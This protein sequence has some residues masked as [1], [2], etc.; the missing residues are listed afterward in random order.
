MQTS[1]AQATADFA[2]TRD[3]MASLLA[4]VATLEGD[5]GAAGAPWTPGRSLS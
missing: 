1:L 4:E 2:A 5:I 3:S